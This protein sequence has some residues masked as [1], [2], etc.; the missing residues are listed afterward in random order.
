MAGP[1]ACNKLFHFSFIMVCYYFLLT[2][3]L[4]NAH[5]LLTAYVYV[6][7]IIVYAYG[8]CRQQQLSED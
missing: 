4:D 3:L 2:Y 5:T 6:Y 7:F 1:M 8:V